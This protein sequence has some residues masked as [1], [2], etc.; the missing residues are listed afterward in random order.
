MRTQITLKLKEQPNLPV[1]AENITP[2]NFIG[3]SIDEIYEIPLL[4]GNRQEKIGDYF[5]VEAAE[6]DDEGT[7]A[8]PQDSFPKILLNGDFSRFKRIGQ[9]MTAGEIVIRGSIGFH[10]GAMMRGGAIRI[11]GDA[12]DWLG[13][14][15]EGGEIIVEGSAGHYVGSAYRGRTKG[16]TG[17]RILIH[18]N[19]GQ[20]LGSRMGGGLIATAGDCGDVPGYK[21]R[22]GT[23]LIAGKAGIRAGAGMLR[24]TIILSGEHTL[25]PTF[26][27]NCSYHPSFWGLLHQ[28]L[29]GKGFPLADFWQG[30]AFKRYSGDGLAGGKGEVL[31]CQ[32][33]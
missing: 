20:M 12:G 16:M 13:A 4:G 31:I 11:L 24:G 3:K 18:G 1:E 21:M 30:A 26:Y 19:A 28:E 23:I 25:L 7:Q 9:A 8:I 27:Y 6:A 33:N 14:H 29:K 15:M 10:T 32:S 22:A 17:G 5:I 2:D